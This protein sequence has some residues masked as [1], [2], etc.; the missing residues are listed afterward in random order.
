MIKGQ[1]DKGQVVQIR[2]REVVETRFGEGFGQLD[3]AL[4][5][6]AAKDD[7]IAIF[8]PTDWITLRIGQHDRFKGI[9]R[10]TVCIQFLDRLRQRTGTSGNL[11]RRHLSSNLLPVLRQFDLACAPEKYPG[12]GGTRE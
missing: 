12:A 4:T 2:A 3:L 7:R 1:D 11:I 9:I 6:P 5:A 8:D 10:L